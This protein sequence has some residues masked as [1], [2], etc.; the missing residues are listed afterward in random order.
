MKRDATS[1]P[2]EQFMERLRLNTRHV[3]ASEAN[4]ALD[5][6]L[7]RDAK[8]DGA[9]T[10]PEGAAQATQSPPRAWVDLNPETV[11]EVLGQAPD[12]HTLA[13]LRFDVLA[14]FLQLEA[15]VVSGEIGQRALMV[16]GLPLG[17]WLDLADVARLLREGK[18][19]P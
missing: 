16:R 1:T 14:A 9:V 2:F 12:P 4:Y 11:R 8:R 7:K 3:H 6:D 15:E 19:R 13:C 10:L 5:K 17:L 18:A